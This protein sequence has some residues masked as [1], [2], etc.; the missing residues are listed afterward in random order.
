MIWADLKDQLLHSHLTEKKNEQGVH[1]AI[2][3]ALE[4]RNSEFDDNI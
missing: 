1:E 3:Q 4:Y 2:S